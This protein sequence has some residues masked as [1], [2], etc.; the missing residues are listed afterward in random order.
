ME[1]ARKLQ[2]RER[3]VLSSVADF[4]SVDRWNSIRVPARVA[5]RAFLNRELNDDGCWIS[6]YSAGSHGYAQ[7][8]WYADRGTKTVLAHRASWV[9]V[10]GQV[11]LGMTID[12]T[13]KQRRCVNPDHLRLL[14]NYENARR[15]DGRDWPMGTCANGHGNDLLVERKTRSGGGSVICSVCKRLYEHRGN[16][17]ARHPGEPMPERLLLASERASMP[18]F[19]TEE[20]S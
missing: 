8:G 12:H 20:D 19:A 10:N 9:H 18:Q 14:P 15:V 11:P 13:C 5:E 6:R 16:W 3:A 7:I 2:R 4:R 17:R 1:H